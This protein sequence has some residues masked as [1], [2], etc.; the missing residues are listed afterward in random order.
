MDEQLHKRILKGPK[1]KVFEHVAAEFAAIW[2]E[3]GRSQGMSSRYKDARSFARAKFERF[4][5]KAIE[6]CV[7]LLDRQDIPELAKAEIYEALMERN[8]DPDVNKVTG[9]QLPDINIKALIDALPK[10]DRLGSITT[11]KINPYLKVN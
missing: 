7:Q 10:Q 11:K 1:Y 6:H 8:N 3:T 4:I 5:P 2:W 9:N